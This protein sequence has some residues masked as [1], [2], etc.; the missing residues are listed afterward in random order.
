M[1]NILVEPLVRRRTYL[2]LLYLLLAFPLGIAYFVGLVTGI[3][4]G[5]GL[6]IVWVGV[7][8]LLGLAIAWRGVARMERRLAILL[9]GAE[10]ESPPPLIPTG[11]S[12]WGRVKALFREAHTWTSL[13]WL[14]LRF[15]LGIAGFVTL[16]TLVSFGLA[17]IASPFIILFTPWPVELWDNVIVIYTVQ[18]TIPLVAIGA[19]TLVVTAHVVNGLAWIHS[20]GA[21]ALLGP[22]QRERMR[23]LQ[24]RTAVLEER[25]ELGRELH[26]SIGHT[27][28]VNTLQA[29]AAQEVFD[30]NPEFARNVLG[31][32]ADS[33][34]RAM[35]ELDRALQVLGEDRPS[36]R[37]P[38]PELDQIER[39]LADARS[40]G[41]PVKLQLN[42]TTAQ[43][44]AEMGRSLYRILQEALTNV[45]RH[46]GQV[47]TMV[48]LSVEPDHVT[49][50]VDNV[51][52]RLP[53]SVPERKA[54]TG[55]G[56]VGIRERVA[57]FDGK[58]LYGPTADAGFSLE[59][60]FP[61][62]VG[63]SR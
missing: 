33:G 13:L 39:L 17:A 34:R 61:L 14:L 45:M 12:I 43:V 52:P 57:L 36:E 29:G 7:P 35:D 58:L 62:A 21:E 47:E 22:S 26:D 16:I 63:S 51:A 2:R 40:A 48:A 28:T 24:Q 54:G 25:T 27:I 15:P 23:Q 46:A 1:I 31:D 3:S 60:V 18:G 53:S 41:L 55:R 30:D 11:G 56:L 32:I 9:L 5:I 6:T 19:V 20:R 44:P 42:G 50:V 38:A 10:I 37:E 59:V 49:L 8:I 4:T